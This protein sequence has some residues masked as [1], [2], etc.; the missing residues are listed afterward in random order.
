MSNHPKT[1]AAL[2]REDA[3]AWDVCDAIAEE[4]AF[5]GEHGEI[6]ALATEAITAG[7]V[8]MDVEMFRM[9]YHA[10]RVSRDSTR[11]QNVLMRASHP[12]AIGRLASAGF[13]P[14][15]IVE[16]VKKS[17]LGRITKHDATAIVKAHHD[18]PA[19]SDDPADWDADQWA[20]FDKATSKAVEQFMLALHY[21]EI[22]L[23][24]PGVEVSMQ[25][26][27]VRPNVDW[28]AELAD[29]TGGTR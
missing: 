14:E 3:S 26:Q 22:G 17:A 12:S 11:T 20:K 18:R 4:C 27:I 21:K 2:Q 10:A 16:V 23:Y 24:T 29:L 6:K 19:K 13:T 1:I 8:S 28:D 9:R 7:V 25:L 5:T 15:A